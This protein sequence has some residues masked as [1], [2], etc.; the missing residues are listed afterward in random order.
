MLENHSFDQMLG[1]LESVIPQIDG[2]DPAAPG[3][4]RDADGT[5][6]S[7]A[8]TTAT[9]ISHDPK[10]DLGN[11]LHQIEGGNANFVLDYLQAYPDT[12]QEER[13]QIMGYFPPGSLGPLHELAQHFTVCDRWF[14]SVPGPT[15]V[16]RF[17]IHSGTSLGR[18]KM[19]EDTADGI[20]HPS[21]YFGYDQD[22]IYDRL[23]KRSIPWRI[24][25]GDFP[26]SLVLAHQRTVGNAMHYERMAVFFNDAQGQEEHFPA[27]SFIEPSYYWPEQNDDHPPHTTV[28]ARRC[29]HTYST[30]CE[31][32]TAFGS[33][34]SWWSSTTSMAVSTTMFRHRRRCLLTTTTPRKGLLSTGSAFVFRQY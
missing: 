1:G 14:S 5:V 30:R 9:S 19:P 29:W 2:V 16:N 32:T 8:Q 11:V 24:Y 10:H 15:W 34:R 33:P 4:N 20:R 25:H 22:T 26:Q 21:L 28:R 13:E 31:A 7:Q 6:Y 12:T 18:V 23:N 17:F 3:Q 27:Y